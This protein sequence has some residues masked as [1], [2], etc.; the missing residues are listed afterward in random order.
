MW[1]NASE[2]LRIYRR[3]EWHDK[4][5]KEF[6]GEEGKDQELFV[7][8]RGGFI[9]GQVPSKIVLLGKQLSASG[10]RKNFRTS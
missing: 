7:V 3:S 1:G 9:K 5:F 6:V 10:I 2:G 8:Q 4:P